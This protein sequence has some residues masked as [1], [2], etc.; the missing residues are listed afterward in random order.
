MPLPQLPEDPANNMFCARD[1]QLASTTCSRETYCGSGNNENSC[2]SYQHCWHR[3]SCDVREFIPFEE[4]GWLGKPTHKEIAE[5][6]GLTYPSVDPTDHY[7]CGTTIEHASNRCSHPCPDGLAL[8]C[9]VGEYCFENTPCDVRVMPTQRPTKQPTPPPLTYDSRENYSFCG[10]SWTSA[11]SCRNQWC[12]DGSECPSGQSCFADTECNNMDKTPHDD[13]KNFMF[14]GED[15]SAASASCK[16][17]G[18]PRGCPGGTDEECP[19]GLVCWADTMCNMNDFTLAPTERPTNRPT[20]T[21]VSPPTASPVRYDDLKHLR[22]C[23]QTYMDAEAYCSIDMH[24][25]SGQNSECKDNSF[26]WV[27][28]A[29]ECNIIAIIGPTP[30]PSRSPTQTPTTRYMPSASPSATP[31]ASPTELP[32]GSPM[33]PTLQ[34]TTRTQSPISKTKYLPQSLQ[35]LPKPPRENSQRIRHIIESSKVSLESEIFVIEFRSGNLIPSSLYTYNGFFECLRFFTENGVNGQFL[36]LGGEHPISEMRILEVE[37]GIANLALFL[38]KMMDTISH[39]RCHPDNLACGLPALDKSFE[40][41]DFRVQCSPPYSGM[42]C[43]SESGCNCVLGILNR[44]IGGANWCERKNLLKSVCS[45]RIDQGEEFRWIT[46]MSHW[47]LFIQQYNNEYGW[48]YIDALKEFVQ[49]GMEDLSFVTNVATLSVLEKETTLMEEQKYLENF[50]NV[51]M[52]LSEGATNPKPVPPPDTTLPTTPPSNMRYQT[53]APRRSSSP[54][55]SPSKITLF[56]PTELPSDTPSFTPTNPLTSSTHP[57]VGVGTNSPVPKSSPP[58]VSADVSTAAESSQ[59]P[60]SLPSNAPVGSSISPTRRW[61]WQYQEETWYKTFF[62][63]N[64]TRR[65]VAYYNTRI[66]LALIT[67]LF[68]Y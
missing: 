15:W 10:Y 61:H 57:S 27:V 46:A 22:F 17:G 3:V 54:S 47:I 28:M 33:V 20:Q 4:G 23:G 52:K 59:P 6:M 68:I 1:W 65:N 25:P 50:L 51:M 36:Y 16:D 13:A 9:A 55:T 39:E 21:P 5:S 49:G 35:S 29:P 53:L 64:G 12:G 26:C 7:F 58:S 34:P 11:N 2:P 41:H 67:Y 42:E 63:P 32:T 48:Q 30:P 19:D 62:S 38:A 45:R 14:C 24:C 44:F 56:K 60:G 43:P 37:Y 66:I 31:S 40:E 18:S 8:S